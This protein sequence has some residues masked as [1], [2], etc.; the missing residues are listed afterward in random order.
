MAHIKKVI[1]VLGLKEMTIPEKIEKG[2]HIV[3]EMTGNPNFGGGGTPITPSLAD[4]TTAV[5][6]LEEAHDAAQSGGTEETAIQH[7][8]ETELD[9]LLTGLGHYVEDVANSN[10]ETAESVGLS[11]G[12]DLKKD[13]EPVGELDKAVLKK[14]EATENIG[15]F[16]IDWDTVQ[17]ARNYGLRAYTDEAD[18]EGSIVFRDSVSPSKATV[19]GLPSGEKVFV[20]VRANGGSTGHG[21]WSDAAWARPR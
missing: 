18:P 3:T 16:K 2:R 9:R 7:E 21:P 1:V 13:A 12:M 14:V 20:Q 8:K 11:S 19:P 17:H 4:I 5:D 6:E 15:E 10:P